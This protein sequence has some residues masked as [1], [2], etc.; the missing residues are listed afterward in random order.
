[1]PGLA[2]VVHAENGRY[3]V[4]ALPAESPARRLYEQEIAANASMPA[5]IPAPQLRYSSRDDGW[6]LMVFDFLEA[7]DADLSPGSPDLDGVLATLASVSAARAWSGAP[8]VTANL[9]ILEDKAARLLARR[10]G[11]QPWDMYRA[12]IAGFDTAA[13]A[14]DRLIHYDLHSGNLK[15]TEDANVVAVDWAFACAGAPWI[16][17]A[18]LVPR[19]IEAGHS[20][21]GAERLVSDLPAWQ[22]AP[23]PA[24]TALAALWTMFREYKAS[25]GPEEARPF[26][27]QAAQAGR[28]WVKYRGGSV[29]A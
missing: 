11:R 18:F 26:R 2:T 8:R 28:S 3:F 21:A 4:K 1:M 15:V 10:T 16:D 14:G 6:L 27:E 19:L 25:Y 23:A 7:R 24:V 17:A 5:G 13:L 20:P 12:A 9:P 22:T 29:P